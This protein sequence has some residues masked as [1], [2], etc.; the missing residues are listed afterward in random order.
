MS[1]T[2]REK[3]ERLQA[4]RQAVRA[5]LEA[6]RE[7]QEA[8]DLEAIADLEVEHGPSN[9]SVLRINYAPGLPSL[10]AVRV[11]SKPEM[12]RYRDMIKPGTDSRN[13]VKVGD[14]DAAYTQVGRTCLVYPPEGD[15]REALYDQR[16]AVQLEAGHAAVKLGETREA[17]EGK[18]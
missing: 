17:D 15:L 3:I 8:S 11:P 10:I 4:Q 12:K 13:K 18:D 7:E 2:P 1:E 16:S 6:Q 9:V 5:A 14:F